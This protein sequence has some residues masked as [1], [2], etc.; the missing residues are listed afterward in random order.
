MKISK[1]TSLVLFLVLY[2]S[3]KA[4]PNL[5]EKTSLNGIW[6]QE[7]YGRIIEIKDSTFTYYNTTQNSCFPLA[8]GNLADRFKVVQLRDN[9]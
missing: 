7:G 6:I 5:K 9:E 3:P 4:F 2:L 1:I 8:S